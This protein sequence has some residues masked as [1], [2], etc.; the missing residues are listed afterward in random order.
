MSDVAAAQ[1][2][3]SSIESLKASKLQTLT[4]GE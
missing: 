1:E 4:I 2:F 3:C